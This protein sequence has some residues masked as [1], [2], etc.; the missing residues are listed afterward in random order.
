[1][2]R[3]A[4]LG[5]VSGNLMRDFFKGRRRKGCIA[6]VMACAFASC[7]IRSLDVADTLR[8]PIG[9]FTI[10]L[11]SNASEIRL[12]L[13]HSL[14][15]DFGWN[16]RNEFGG[17]DRIYEATEPRFGPFQDIRGRMH[18]SPFWYLS[19]HSE[20]RAFGVRVGHGF[21]GQ[22]QIEILYL[23][24]PCWILVL[25][26]TLLSAYLILWKRRKKPV[27]NL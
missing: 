3:T 1:M 11:S 21:G 13:H 7:W 4:A 22:G 10:T 26:L 24:L 2:T 9:A 27:P 18:S 25:S 19:E 15:S 5:S 23:H 14:S 20:V 17:N 8:I 12:E 6:L 16:P